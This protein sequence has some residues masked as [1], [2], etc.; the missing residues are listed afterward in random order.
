MGAMESSVLEVTQVLHQA[1]ALVASHRHVNL[2]GGAHTVLAAAPA[3][4]TSAVVAPVST[5]VQ[6]EVDAAD[7]V[8][9]RN[10]AQTVA[11]AAPGV[12]AHPAHAVVPHTA[13][14]VV[15]SVAPS[16]AVAPVVSH[17]VGHATVHAAPSVVSHGVSHVSHGVSHVSHGVS[18]VSHGH[19]G[20]ATVQAAAPAAVVVHTPVAQTAALAV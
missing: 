14:T 18:H 9:L 12:V 11:H 4:A 17:G 3:V 1:P 2:G 16:L 13:P 8:N 6:T 10:A 19:G 5:E 20:H 7:V 15:Q